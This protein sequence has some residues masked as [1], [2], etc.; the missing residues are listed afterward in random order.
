[1]KIRPIIVAARLEKVGGV[2]E[3]EALTVAI[4]VVRLSRG[5]ME[6]M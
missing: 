6:E 4:S 3:E 1:M 2:E 5:V